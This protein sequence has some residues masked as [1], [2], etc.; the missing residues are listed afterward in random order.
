[1]Q[2]NDQKNHERSQ[3]VQEVNPVSRDDVFVMGHFKYPLIYAIFAANAGYSAIRE[4]WM[5]YQ[6]YNP[7][8]RIFLYNILANIFKLYP[9]SSD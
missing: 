1:M 2:Y 9:K 6:R 8:K 4:C 7:L 3:I 5:P